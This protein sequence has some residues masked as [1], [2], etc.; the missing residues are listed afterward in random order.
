MLYSQA[1]EAYLAGKHSKSLAIC[2]K[3]LQKNQKDD[4]T[5]NLYGLLQGVMGNTKQSI[6]FFEKA[7]AVNPKNVEAMTNLANAYKASG[8]LD[9]ALATYKTAID[10]SPEFSKSYYNAGVVL[11]ELGRVEEAKD[12]LSKS[13]E[14]DDSFIDSYINL[15]AAYKDEGDIE[16]A[17]EVL[18][19]SPKDDRVYSSL[20]LLFSEKKEHN[21]AIEYI[22]QAILIK[23]NHEMLNNL[24]II[25]SG[26]KMYEQAVLACFEAISMKGDFDTAY[27]NLANCFIDLN[28]EQKAKGALL[29]AI[30]INPNCA[31]H[32]VN[33]GVFFKKQGDMMGAE[34]AFL[35]ALLLDSMNK[36]AS[37]NLAIL[38]LYF[39]QY[40]DGLPL[41]ERRTKP[42]IRTSKPYWKGESL[43]GK[44][45]FVY[46]EQ[47]FGD[48]LNFARLLNHEK[49]KGRDVCFLP[50]KELYSLFVSSILPSRVLS[51]DEVSDGTFVFDFHIPLLSLPYV[52]EIS[53]NQIPASIN[54]VQVDMIKKRFF[55]NK[56]AISNKKKIGI[57]W[58]GNKEHIGDS[59]RSASVSLFDCF[60]AS[61]YA[62]VSLQKEMDTQSSSI[63][64]GSDS[65]FEFS[66]HL[67]TF[68][69][70]AALIANL[71][72]VVSVDTS[73]AHLASVMDIPTFILLASIPD[74]RWGVDAKKT[75]WYENTILCRQAQKG[76]WNSAMECALSGVNRILG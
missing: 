75:P 37:T 7:L 73:V 69:D 5:L 57:V 56:L 41:Y 66:T 11:R 47:G 52:L 17:I 44:R 59:E 18:D 49:L 34:Q 23:R 63:F 12:L 25:Y 71:D 10:T 28:D 45:L 1:V 20:A 36:P 14:L 61:G 6:V 65:L 22:N 32:Y 39:G 51:V 67:N 76:D 58:Q 29:K 54:Y 31:S 27:S 53:E 74:W 43:D 15:S 62:L 2:Q 55:A 46:H 40:S 3:I 8:E 35:S 21:K 13:I 70:T 64:A 68:A 72:C 50:Q 16:R 38:K 60:L 42:F 33:L 48:S 26:A 19:A 9:K 24:G 4:R 30:S